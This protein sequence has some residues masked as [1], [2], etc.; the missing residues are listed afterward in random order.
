MH[1]ITYARLS[2]QSVVAYLLQPM[3]NKCPVVIDV[4]TLQITRQSSLEI[5]NYCMLIQQLIQILASY[6]RDVYALKESSCRLQLL[7]K[8]EQQLDAISEAA[9]NYHWWETSLLRKNI[10]DHNI[11]YDTEVHIPII[12]I[13]IICAAPCIQLCSGAN[14]DNSFMHQLYMCHI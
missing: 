11:L 12:Q 1:P 3:V 5:S 9:L 2:V 4:V 10:F 7:K 6:M 13:S 8:P 14:M